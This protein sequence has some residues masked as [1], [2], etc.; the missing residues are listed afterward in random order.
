MHGLSGKSARALGVQALFVLAL[1]PEAA[2]GD[3]QGFFGRIF[4][5][6]GNPSSSASGSAGR[7]AGATDR[8]APLPY[9]SAE[10][11]SSS[12]GFSGTGPRSTATNPKLGTS[13][14]GPSTPELAGDSAAQSRISPRPRA[15]GAV[16]TA[17][18]ILTRMALG[19]SNDGSQFGMFL[20]VFAD[21]T[22]IDSDG[23]HKLGA[24]DIRPIAELIQ[25]GELARA[26]GH[27][28]SPAAD[29]VEYVHVVVFERRMGR[30]QAHSLSYSGNPQGCDSSIRQLHTVLEAMQAKL[31][32]QP[33]AGQPGMESNS[34]NSAH[35][36]ASG[37]VTSL[38][39][40]GTNP[41]AG[42]GRIPPLPDPGAATPPPTSRGSVIPLSPLEPR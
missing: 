39:V 7:S 4:R 42:Q 33:V 18:P 5:L 12:F 26:R 36:A 9:R 28:S 14:E 35:A 3:D 31:S 27:C 21:G 34:P 8:S 13:T 29:F 38:P 41:D 19:R 10:G 25:G 30:L 20:Q 22:V 23:V 24:S 1:A 16:T 11:P 37:P 15:S 40:S 2:L 32:R 6:G 17:D